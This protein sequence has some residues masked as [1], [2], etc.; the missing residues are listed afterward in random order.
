VTSIRPQLLGP[1]RPWREP[2]KRWTP[3][4]TAASRVRL[5]G[6]SVP[7]RTRVRSEVAGVVR[8]R[9]RCS[10]AQSTDVAL[11]FKALLVLMALSGVVACGDDDG[12]SGNL[13]ADLS[14]ERPET[15]PPISGQ[16]CQGFTV[17]ALSRQW[18]GLAKHWQRA[19]RDAGPVT[20]S[21]TTTAR[22]VQETEHPRAANR[23]DAP[24][25]EPE[26]TSAPNRGF[27][28]RIAAPVLRAA[29]AGVSSPSAAGSFGVT[30]R[31]F[32]EAGVEFGPSGA[33]V[34]L[35]VG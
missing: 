31:A 28:Q 18:R 5:G 34:L 1:Q 26:R 32:V 16:C 33:A 13:A 7:Q 4:W 35:S 19:S 15:T 22:V 30:A 3:R 10:L 8:Y 17:R 20:Q 24:G 12:H 23:S 9:R 29:G 11:M 2:V 6:R 14:T 21:G 27:G 25:A